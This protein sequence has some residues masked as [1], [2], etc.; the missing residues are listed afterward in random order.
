MSICQ[1]MSEPKCKFF[2]WLV[3]HGRILTGN[4]LLKRNW[5][6]NY[7]CSLCLHLH[8]TTEHLLTQCNYTKVV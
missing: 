3:M 4:N 6:C 7:K 2:A 5:S 8:E 1:A